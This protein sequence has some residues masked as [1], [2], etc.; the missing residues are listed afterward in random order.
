MSDV[1]GAPI[2]SPGD[3]QGSG[4]PFPCRERQP[5]HCKSENP[6]NSGSCFRRSVFACHRN[7]FLCSKAV[8]ISPSP[9][10]FAGPIANLGVA[11]LLSAHEISRS[12]EARCRGPALVEARERS[13]IASPL[14][15]SVRS[16]SP[17]S[18]H[19]RLQPRRLRRTGQHDA[20]E[21]E[22]SPVAA[23]TRS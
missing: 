15:L 6:D 14:F 21:A 9:S 19:F 7:I 22:V 12:P 8:F 2:A 3:S 4:E 5:R 20:I 10:A 18:F 17:L 11:D 13:L 23:R 1:P 16:V